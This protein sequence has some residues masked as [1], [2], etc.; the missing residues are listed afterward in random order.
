MVRAAAGVDD[1]AA[2]DQADDEHDLERGEE[3]F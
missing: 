3:H 2:D 1:D